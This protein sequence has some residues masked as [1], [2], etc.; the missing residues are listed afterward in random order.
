LTAA[1]NPA[2]INFAPGWFLDLVGTGSVTIEQ[3]PL[4]STLSNPTNAPYALHIMLSG[5]WT[6]PPVLRQRFQQNGMLWANKTVS[7]S[8]TARTNGAP[9]TITSSLVASNGQPLVGLINATLT[10]AFVE[11]TAFGVLP[12][13][14]NP[15]VP[16]AAYIEYQTFL[17]P[18]S[19]LYLTSFQL[20][21]SDAAANFEY[22]QDTI[23]RQLDH[24][25]HYYDPL[26]AYKP[27]P[28]YLVGWDFPLNPAQIY[29]DNVVAFVG[30]NSG[31][32]LWDQTIG[33][34]TV[35]SS[36]TTA[37]APNGGLQL[38][39]AMAGQVAILQYLDEIEARKIL[40]D[41]ASVHISTSTTA[42]AGSL[43]GNVTLW[44][45]TDATL[46]NL[47]AGITPITA[48]SATGVPTMG[49]GTW[50]QVPNVYQD[51]EFTLTPASATNS[52]SAD[53]SLSGWDM[54]GA[55]P[56][57][58]ATFF[59]IVVGFSPW[60]AADT[61]SIDSISLCAGDI[62]TRPSPKTYQETLNDCQQYY[63]MSYVNFSDVGTITLENALVATQNVGAY[64]G[65]GG[66]QTYVSESGFG[67]NYNSLKR[68][69]IPTITL[70]STKTVNTP[71]FVTMN[72][73][74]AVIASSNDPITNWTLDA[75]NKGA[76]YFAI[77]FSGQNYA[78]DGT[79]HVL[80]AWL[81]YHYIVDARLGLVN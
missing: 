50:V 45:T 37:R 31:N 66:A 51:T 57:N 54:Q 24:L 61:I 62:A 10:N 27:I 6:N 9:A 65:A 29:G 76:N 70:Y 36:F 1:T 23:D 72:T 42:T 38:T 79:Y 4:S 15:D 74:G 59:V 35:A 77:H 32:Y 68:T 80:S 21:V 64:G 46:P 56:T 44:A 2:P 16:P 71:N 22:Q 33:Y 5:T 49:N 7:A 47:G 25:A 55:V 34:Q 18:T 8:I 81:S 60:I 17:P 69:E 20:V 48:L 52:E 39:C 41:R 53:I 63:E 43:T 3:I 73:L 78:A 40:S 28:S 30:V 75:G 58:T 12:A 67:F 26:L 19:D 11:Y 13:T 14:T